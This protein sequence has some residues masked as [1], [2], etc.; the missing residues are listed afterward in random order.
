MVIM[1][2][3]SKDPVNVKGMYFVGQSYQQKSHN[4]EQNHDNHSMRNIILVNN[5][6]RL[7]YLVHFVAM[8]TLHKFIINFFKFQT[9]Q[10]IFFVK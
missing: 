5:Q 6:E 2:Q 7:F 3:Q 8:A 1:M 4:L 9:T 10:Y